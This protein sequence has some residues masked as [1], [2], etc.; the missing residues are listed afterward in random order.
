MKII[1][2]KICLESR[3]FSDVRAEDGFCC[4]WNKVVTHQYAACWLLV[5]YWSLQTTNTG[6][7]KALDSRL[8]NQTRSLR[9]VS[10]FLSDTCIN[11]WLIVPAEHSRSHVF[12]RHLTLFLVYLFFNILTK[13]NW[14]ES[15]STPTV[16]LAGPFS[17]S[18]KCPV[19]LPNSLPFEIK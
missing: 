2:R 1:W 12:G 19:N 15:S 3:T 7:I 8:K 18:A 17:S 4:S 5:L 6:Y 13:K 14:W 9:M 11:L 10:S 16:K